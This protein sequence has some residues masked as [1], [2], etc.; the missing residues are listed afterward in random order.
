MENKITIFTDENGHASMR[1]FLA[2]ILALASVGFG[3]GAIFIET[4]WQTLLVAMGLPLTGSL[5]FMFFTTWEAVGSV[6]SAV[7]GKKEH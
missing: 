3:I 5:L 1:R 6:I 4:T 2:F 7:K